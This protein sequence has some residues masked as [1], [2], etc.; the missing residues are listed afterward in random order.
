MVYYRILNICNSFLTGTVPLFSPSPNLFFILCQSA[1]LKYK[2]VHFIPL[3]K[4]LQ[5]FPVAYRVKF[6]LLIMAHPSSGS[7]LHFQHHFL[8]TLP[9]PVCI[10]ATLNCLW[11]LEL[12]MF[13]SRF[14]FWNF[15]LAWNFLLSWSALWILTFLSQFSSSYSSVMWTFKNIPWLSPEGW[16]SVRIVCI[17]FFLLPVKHLPHRTLFLSPIRQWHPWGQNCFLEFEIIFLTLVP[18]IYESGTVDICINLLGL[19]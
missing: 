2:S 11:L 8:L 19:P 6:K 3:L 4:I 9:S 10:P 7:C 13:S 5:L 14:C 16:G 18:S 17:F 1:S 12:N 15:P